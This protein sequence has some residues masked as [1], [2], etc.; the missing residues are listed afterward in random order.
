MQF[1]WWNCMELGHI[2]ADIQF[3][4]RF[5]GFLNEKI[6]N[7]KQ[8]TFVRVRN[9]WWAHSWLIKCFVCVREAERDTDCC[10]WM[11]PA[12]WLLTISFKSYPLSSISLSLLLSIHPGKKIIIRFSYFSHSEVFCGKW[13]DKKGYI[14]VHI[15]SI[16]MN[17]MF[18]NNY[19]SWKISKNWENQRA[20][21]IV[22]MNQESCSILAWKSWQNGQINY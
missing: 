12:G 4:I 14:Y 17:N 21:D 22:S 9:S 19:M 5:Q 2:L 20:E 16:T 1:K 7:R 11:S 10:D 15:R 3:S 18:L 6:S 13:Q 8:R